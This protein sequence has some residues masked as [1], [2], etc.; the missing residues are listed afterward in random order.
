M[1]RRTLLIVY[2][3][4]ILTGL[5]GATQWVGYRLKYHPALKPGLHIG[6]IVLYPPW[7]MV[8]WIRFTV[9]RNVF[10]TPTAFKS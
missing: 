10:K 4:L 5:A 2:L 6:P 8:G 3:G 1:K 7:A 9:Q